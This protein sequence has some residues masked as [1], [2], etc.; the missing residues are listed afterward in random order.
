MQTF[1]VEGKLREKL[2]KEAAK[3]YRREGLVTAEAYGAGEKNYH[4]VVKRKDVE[5][6]L[7]ASHGETVLIE[8]EFDGEK[9]LAFIQ[10][11]QREKVKGQIIHVDFHIVHKEEKVEVT[12]PVVVKGEEES[13]GI[14]KGG[15]LDIQLHEL[16]V[17]AL[18]MAV[19]GHIEID[20]SNMDIGDVVYV[21]DIKLEGVEFEHDD[22][23][24]ILSIVAPRMEEEITEE[25]EEAEGEEAEGEESAQEGE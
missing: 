9:K 24:V 21:K 16:T 17:W 18:P 10:D 20:V 4:L 14:K 12:V 2:G 22:D 13:P 6:V 1:K 3:K 5:D 11:I 15:I 8:L 25:V 7:R 19:P 23:E